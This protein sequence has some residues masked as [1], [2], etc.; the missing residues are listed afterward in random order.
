MSRH[1]LTTA[2]AATLLY[3][4]AG[5]SCA[6]N[7]PK[8]GAAQPIVE[9]AKAH[10][11]FTSEEQLRQ[12]DAVPEQLY[13]I[14]LMVYRITLPAGA[15]SRSDDFWKHV[16]EH[17]VDVA[18]YE[19][20]YKNG[21]RVG[22]APIAEWDYFK[23]LLDNHPALT[24]PMTYTGRAGNDIELE[25]RKNVPLQHIFYFDSTGDLIGRTYERCNDL[26]RL[27][28]QPAPRKHGSVRLG[29]VPIVQS[30]REQ[31]V[32]VGPLNTRT[33]TWFKP[34]HL[35]ELNLI[36]DVDIEHFLVIAPSPEARW[37]SSLGNIFLTADGATEQTET[38]IVVR[39]MMFRQKAEAPPEQA[40]T[41]GGRG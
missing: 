3:A 20:L 38:L 25:M 32:P 35:Y 7:Q 29:L 30:L 5:A 36:A 33:V 41:P 19:L 22:V 12:A 14:Q 39:P 1:L 17:A 11:F 21:V 9:Q 2:I 18:T 8:Y 31:L 24:Q 28:Y 34:E 23:G 37:P 15:V 27:S 6:S 40:K 13:V 16:D 4:F 26:L 10:S